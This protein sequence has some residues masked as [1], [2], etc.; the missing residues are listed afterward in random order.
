MI[1]SHCLSSN[2]LCPGVINTFHDDFVMTKGD[3]EERLFLD[4]SLQT[5]GEDDTARFLLEKAGVDSIAVNLR[6]AR[7]FLES[8]LFVALVCSPD[9]DGGFAFYFLLQFLIM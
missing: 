4:S 9:A 3:F 5:V 6:P 1:A 8:C 7:S 2:C